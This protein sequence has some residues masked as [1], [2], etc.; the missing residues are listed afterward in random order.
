MDRRIWAIAL[1]ALLLLAGT[2]VLAQDKPRGQMLTQAELQK[3]TLHGVLIT[4]VDVPTGDRFSSTFGYPNLAHNIILQGNGNARAR[5]GTWKIAE[6]R[7]CVTY[8]SVENCRVHY[9][10]DDGS[11]EAWSGPE[12][13]R[14]LIYRVSQ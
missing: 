1:M 12:G 10:L 9:K 11:Y 6:G 5:S 4:G 3:L 2:A 13:M 8:D 14:L 7:F